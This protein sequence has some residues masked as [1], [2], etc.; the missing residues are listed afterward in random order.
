[1]KGCSSITR[2]QFVLM[3]ENKCSYKNLSE[4]IGLQIEYLFEK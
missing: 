3:F 4:E 2:A 1:V